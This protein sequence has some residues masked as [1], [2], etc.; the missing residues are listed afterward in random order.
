MSWIKDNKFLV[1]L[2]GA[3]LVGMVVLYFVGAQGASSYDTSKE[4]FQ[5]AADEAV[6]FEK[7]PIY[8]KTEN[9]NM[10]G[11]ALDDYR[12]SLTSLQNDFS[13][14]RPK[15]IK[16]ISPQE[17]TDHL[18]AAN[19]AVRKAFED[20]GTTVPEPFFVG[21]EEYSKK[22][23]APGTTGLLEYQLDSIRT[24]MIALSKAKPSELKNLHRPALP[25]ERGSKF[26]S[27]NAV[28]RPFPLEIVFKGPEKSVRSFLSS[29]MTLEDQYVV[30][31]SLRIENEK[32]DAPK[33]ADAKFEKPAEAAPAAADIFSGFVL[34]G[35]EAP[36]V[37]AGGGAEAPAP[38][39]APAPAPT[40]DSGKILAQV[41]GSEETMVFLRL[42]V[43][44]FLPAKKLP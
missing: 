25:E 23:A 16:N 6:Q 15:E 42:D 37:P 13:A 33:V 40:A 26:N 7:L 34:P 41:L 30:I 24:L 32:K 21:F 2:G 14:Y 29:L 20:S 18:L 1:A 28:A 39:A 9:A 5:A 4:N 19:K 8:P 31:R 22:L 36:A 17:F 44:E 12:G 3:T 43:L 10:K 38:E 35:E 27:G 11:K